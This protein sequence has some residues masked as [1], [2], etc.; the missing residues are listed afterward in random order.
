MK[1]Y[2]IKAV[3]DS[4]ASEFNGLDLTNGKIHFIKTSKA[5]DEHGLYDKG[6]AVKEFDSNDL[7]KTNLMNEPINWVGV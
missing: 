3:E 7:P 6:V 2:R 1:Y 5:L 4:E